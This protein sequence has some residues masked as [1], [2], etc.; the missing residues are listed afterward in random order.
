M[1]RTVD[2]PDAQLVRLVM[3]GAPREWLWQQ[4]EG[5]GIVHATVGEADMQEAP[6]TAE[7]LEEMRIQARR[8][9]I[10]AWWRSGQGAVVRTVLL[11]VVHMMLRPVWRLR[12]SAGR[13]A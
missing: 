5:I 11:R 8:V 6:V 12:Q 1:R 9:A 7:R 4:P 2:H 10:V 13:I 3:A